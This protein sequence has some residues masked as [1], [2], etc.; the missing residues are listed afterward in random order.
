MGMLD[1]GRLFRSPGSIRPSKP[2]IATLS[3]DKQRLVAEFCE[4]RSPTSST[5]DR[6]VLQDVA[7]HVDFLTVVNLMPDTLQDSP[8]QDRV[9]ILAIHEPADVFKA[10][11]ALLQF[12]M[13]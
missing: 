11:V 7:D 13:S 12:L 10:D 1:S 2:L 3:K 4:F 9:V 5:L 6:V 8:H